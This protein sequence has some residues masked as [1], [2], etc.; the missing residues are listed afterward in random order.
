M[1]FATEDHLKHE[2][3]SA[4]K[5]FRKL[6]DEHRKLETRLTAIASLQH[7]TE[8]E[9][10]EE[11]NLKRRKLAIKDEIYSILEEHSQGH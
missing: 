2:L 6:V 1:D 10:E 4:D 3:Y 9:I 5:N 8:D 11:A 7:P